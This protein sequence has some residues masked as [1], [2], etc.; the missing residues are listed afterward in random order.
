MFKTTGLCLEGMLQVLLV[1]KQS[2]MSNLMVLV[3]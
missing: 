3:Q 2:F 1:K